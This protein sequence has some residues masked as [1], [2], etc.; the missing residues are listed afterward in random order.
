MKPETKELAA[1]SQLY[2]ETVVPVKTEDSAFKPAGTDV[3]EPKDFA[4]TGP[5]SPGAGTDDT[6]D[7]NKDDGNHYN[8]G[9]L[10]QNEEKNDTEAINNSK[11]MSEKQNTFDKLY[12]DIMGDDAMMMTQDDEMGVDEPG[13]GDEGDLGAEEGLGDPQELLS[14][15]IDALQQLA[16]VLGGGGEEDLPGED[17][18]SDDMGADVDSMVPE[19][20]VQQEMQAHADLKNLAD[21]GAD[22]PKSSNAAAGNLKKVGGTANTGTIKDAP[23]PANLGG[24]GDR[25]HPDAGNVSSG[26]NKVNNPGTPGVG[27]GLYN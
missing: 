11:V 3:S 19:E 21:K 18:P 27:G 6:L 15:A 22:N 20:G 7:V 17:V 23:V 25:S 26:S 10:S 16:D 4:K 8:T 14:T 13:I 5:N 9:N 1:M 12:E 24:H 2:T